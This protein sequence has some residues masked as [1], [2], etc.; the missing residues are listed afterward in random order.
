M[1]AEQATRHD[2][3]YCPDESFESGQDLVDHLTGEH[4][5]LIK[6]ME[7]KVTLHE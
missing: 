7:G 4:N 6:A 1:S 2:C 3:E 5:V